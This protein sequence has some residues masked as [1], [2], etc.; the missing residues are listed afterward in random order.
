MKEAVIDVRHATDPGSWGMTELAHRQWWPFI[1]RDMIIKAK[2]CRTCTE[3]GKN[4][5]IIIPETNLSPFIPCVE[6]NEEI[7]VD[8][9]G[10]LFDGQGREVNFLACIDQFSKYPSPKLYNNANAINIEHFLNKYM[11]KHGLPKSIRKD[12]ARCQ[13]GNIIRELYNRNNMKII[14]APPNDHRSIG[15]F[16]RL[17]QTVKRNTGCIS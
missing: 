7:Q 3:F 11:Y 17:T 16:E 8:F 14:F 6:P 2:T 5:K 13:K 9:G 15:L 1:S 10:P 12:Q 4:L